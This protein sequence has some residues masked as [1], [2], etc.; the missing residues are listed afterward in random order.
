MAAGKRLS[1]CFGSGGE[2]NAELFIDPGEMVDA[3][4]QTPQRSFF[5]ETGQ[6]LIDGGP[7]AKR[8][9]VGGID[10][11]ARPRGANLLTDDA[12]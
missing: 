10:D 9:K 12:H 8:K 1:D 4:P 5:R 2:R 6:H 7:R 3:P 11:R